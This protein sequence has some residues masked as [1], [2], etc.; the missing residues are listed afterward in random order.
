MDQN[1][2]HTLSKNE[3]LKSHALIER[4]FAKGTSYF[5][6]P[7]KLIFLPIENS[8]AISSCYLFGVT[9]PK[10]IHKKAHIRN[11]LKRRIRE[12]YR[13]NKPAPISTMNSVQKYALMYIL[14]DQ[15]I[16]DTPTL[17]HA[18]IKI[19]RKLSHQNS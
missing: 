7:L 19:N 9:V 13:Q 2:R 16:T 8:D 15:N 3:R 5:V 11:L 14:V 10:R 4:L 6:F 12:A 17:V 1:V 18:M